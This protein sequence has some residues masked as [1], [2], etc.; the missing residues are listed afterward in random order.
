MAYPDEARLWRRLLPPEAATIS[1]EDS[2]SGAT[3][4]QGRGVTCVWGRGALAALVTRNDDSGVEGCRLR[5]MTVPKAVPVTRNDYPRGV[6]DD[7][8]QLRACSGDSCMSCS[9]E[10]HGCTH[11]CAS[12]ITIAC[13]A[14]V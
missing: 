12:T 10:A 2:V 14:V 5:R 8:L 3:F 7:F 1:C 9:V 6:G 11:G 4:N 13:A